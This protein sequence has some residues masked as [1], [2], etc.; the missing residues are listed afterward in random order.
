MPQSWSEGMHAGSCAV[1]AAN[2]SQATLKLRA[3][4]SGVNGVRAPS[5]RV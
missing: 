1:E 3:R 5:W 2:D 4:G